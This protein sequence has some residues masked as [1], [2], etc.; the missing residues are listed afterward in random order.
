[1]WLQPN[2]FGN[3]NRT[4]IVPAGLNGFMFG[5]GTQAI[6]QVDTGFPTFGNSYPIVQQR[7]FNAPN[8][9]PIAQQTITTNGPFRHTQTTLIGCKICGPNE[10]GHTSLDHCSDC[11]CYKKHAWNCPQNQSTM[12]SSSSSSS[13]F[14]NNSNYCCICNKYGHTD[15]YHCSACKCYPNHS[16]ICCYASNSSSSNT[17]ITCSMCTGKGH[18]GWKCPSKCNNCGGNGHPGENCTSPCGKCGGIGHKRH[19]CPNP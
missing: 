18:P 11:G 13:S 15:V 7:N 10:P 17:N 12:S 4:Q 2:P 16:P 8:G 19:Q 9:F 5:S 6:V 14:S 3:G 1:M